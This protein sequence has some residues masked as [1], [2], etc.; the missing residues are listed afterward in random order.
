MTARQ[1]IQSY[2]DALTIA[3]AE[4]LISLISSAD[5]FGKIGTDENEVAHG[6]DNA[7][8]Y[9]RHHTASTEDFT[10]DTHYLDVQDRESVAWFTTLQRWN[11]AWQGTRETLEMRLTGVLER[12]SGV[13]R[14]VQIHASLGTQESTRE[15]GKEK[16][17]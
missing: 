7:V 11:L 2:F 4:R 17:E 12:E 9:Y 13:W 5:Y 10:I 8:A 14:F 16:P 15:Q 3:D 6:G 1:T